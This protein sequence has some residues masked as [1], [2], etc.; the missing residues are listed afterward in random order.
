MPHDERP[1]PDHPVCC[2]RCGLEVLVRKHSLA[3]T[4]VQWPVDAS[5]CAGPTV[6]DTTGLRLGCEALRDTIT[7]AVRRRTLEV[8]D[9]DRGPGGTAH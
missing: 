2:D 5:R 7:D 8:P 1:G 9:L 3:H 6:A 4:M